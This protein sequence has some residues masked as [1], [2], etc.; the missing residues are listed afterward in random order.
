MLRKKSAVGRK[1]ISQGLKCLTQTLK[2]NVISIYG[3]TK[4][5]A[6]KLMFCI[7]ARL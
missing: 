4:E 2:P 5:A 1:V 3:P 6:E 7:R